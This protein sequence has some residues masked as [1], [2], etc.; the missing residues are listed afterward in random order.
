MAQLAL[1]AAQGEDRADADGAAQIL[2]RQ[3]RELGE[4]QHA[5]SVAVAR[6]RLPRGSISCATTYSCDTYL[7]LSRGA[8]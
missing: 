2:L 5:G 6:R 8:R 3:A 7:L 4:H 1:H